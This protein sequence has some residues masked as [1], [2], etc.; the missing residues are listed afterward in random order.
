VATATGGGRPTNLGE[1]WCGLGRNQGGRPACGELFLRPASCRHVF[2][3]FLYCMHPSFSIATPFFLVQ[4]LDRAN[5]EAGSRAPV[6]SA[7][8]MLQ[9][10][11]A[12]ALAG[13]KIRLIC[14]TVP[15][16]VLPKIET[17]TSQVILIKATYVLLEK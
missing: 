16:Q 4:G 9:G 6:R 15:T 13:T 5:Q 3:S 12:E 1:I 17:F 7:V 10:W 2:K 11:R 14:I 8:Y